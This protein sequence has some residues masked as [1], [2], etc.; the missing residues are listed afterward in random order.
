MILNLFIILFAAVVALVL[1]DL[2]VYFG[3]FLACGFK[4]PTR[5]QYST[6]APSIF[7]GLLG[8]VGFYCLTVIAFCL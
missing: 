1:L 8:G 5:H 4:F 7:F 6:H 3:V 2:A